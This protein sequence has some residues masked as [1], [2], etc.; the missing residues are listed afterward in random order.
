MGYCNILSKVSAFLSASFTFKTS[1]QLGCD[2]FDEDRQQHF[3]SK[4]SR[5]TSFCYVLCTTA[6]YF[7][8][9]GLPYIAHACWGQCCLHLCYAPMVCCIVMVWSMLSSPRGLVCCSLLPSTAGVALV[10]QLFTP[11]STLCI[12][13]PRSRSPARPQT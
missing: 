13:P 8:Y 1:I 7:G 2:A 3:F 4:R 10:R 6:S 12:S 11:H 9:D 5:I